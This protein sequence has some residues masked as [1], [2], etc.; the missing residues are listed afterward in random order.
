MLCHWSLR[1][2]FRK[3]MGPWKVATP[4]LQVLENHLAQP[5]IQDRV[6]PS[7]AIDNGSQ[8]PLFD[9]LHWQGLTISQE[10]CCIKEQFLRKQSLS[11]CWIKIKILGTSIHWA[12]SVICSKNQLSLIQ[13]NLPTLQIVTVTLFPSSRIG[14]S[15]ALQFLRF[16]LCICRLFPILF[17]VWPSWS[18]LLLKVVHQH[19]SKKKKNWK[20]G[21]REISAHPC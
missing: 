7:L 10:G 18:I 6:S 8:Q 2:Q 4:V 20:Q 21:L 17:W 5:S 14:P 15:Q 1:S 13:I 11:F 12:S 19:I 9:Y 16:K 3:Q